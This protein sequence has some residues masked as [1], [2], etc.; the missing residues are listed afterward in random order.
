MRQLFELICWKQ[1]FFSLPWFVSAI[2]IAVPFRDSPPLTPGRAA[3]M[4]LAFLAARIAAMSCNQ[5]LDAEIDRKNPRT[6]QRPIPSGKIAKS[7]VRGLA[8]S[9]LLTFVCTSLYLSIPCFVVSLFIAPLL[10]VYSFCKRFTWGSHLVLG[11]VQ[12]LLPI[13]IGIA[14]TGALTLEHLLL[15]IGLGS[16]VAAM[17]VLYSL[18]DLSVDR[19]QGLFSIP[20]FFGKQAALWWS[21]GLHGAAIASLAI[22]GAALHLSWVY[23]TPLGGLAAITAGGH[24]WLARHLDRVGQVFALGC[25]LP[26]IVI[27]MALAGAIL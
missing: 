13:S 25:V 16:G 18:Q 20:A 7:H 14:L 19:Q 26:G 22:E 1:T 9:A 23:F 2:L 4:L 24:W 8:I 6:A 12:A 10:V 27:L 3:S 21:R 17:D 15:G 5:W 11:F